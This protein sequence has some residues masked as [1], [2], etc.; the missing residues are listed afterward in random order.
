MLVLSSRAVW[1]G[2][3][4]AITLAW[5][6]AIGDPTILGWTI[7]LA[8]AAGTWLALRAAAIN[9]HAREARAWRGTAG[10]TRAPGARTTDA[11]QREYLVRFWCFAAFVLALLCINKQLDVQTLFTESAREIAK[12][13]GWYRERKS[14]QFALL[15]VA[16]AAAVVCALWMLWML[17]FSLRRVWVAVC[18]LVVL[19]AYIAMRG[20]SHHAVDAFMRLG[21]F[22]LRDSMELVGIAMIAWPAWRTINRVEARRSDLSDWR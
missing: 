22:P 9:L 8:Y 20:T 3:Q 17:R 4:P 7:T 16:F 6:P 1:E 13:G 2:S 21:P 19:A 11:R 15:G 18:G 5:A 12:S 10:E 14:L